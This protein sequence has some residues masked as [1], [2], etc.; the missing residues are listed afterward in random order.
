[1]FLER[2]N[3]KKLYT[4][5][6]SVKAISN[7]RI[8]LHRLSSDYL[9][10]LTTTTLRKTAKEGQPEVAAHDGIVTVE[11]RYRSVKKICALDFKCGEI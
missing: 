1:M 6:R 5:C 4:M 3:G 10:G 9:I 8:A 11:S 7:N 2:W